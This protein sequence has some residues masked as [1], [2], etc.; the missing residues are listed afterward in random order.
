MSSSGILRPVALVRTDAVFLRSVL[1]L[2]VSADVVPNSPILVPLM[3]DLLLSSDMLVLTRAT[4]RHFPEDGI[5]HSS[6][7]LLGI[8][9]L[10]YLS[11]IGPTL[12][13]L[14]QLPNVSEVIL[15]LFLNSIFPRHL[16]LV[17][18]T[19]SPSLE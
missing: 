1:R 5:L 10:R 9:L 15:L 12:D 17:L 3:A 13:P 14:L 8:E 7:I 4:R 18:L 11:E 2:L 19:S 6:C 16:L